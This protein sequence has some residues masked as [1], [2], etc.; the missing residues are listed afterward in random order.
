MLRVGCKT[1]TGVTDLTLK[2]LGI[3]NSIKQ[4][5]LRTYMQWALQRNKNAICIPVNF[6]NL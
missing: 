5:N 4:R 2:K 6:K 3:P 1:S